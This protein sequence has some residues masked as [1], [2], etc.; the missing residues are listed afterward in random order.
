VQALADGVMSKIGELVPVTPVP[1]ACA[2]LQSL[3]RDFVLRSGLLA[4]MTEMRD[5]LVELNARVVREDRDMERTLERALRLLVMRRVL[6]PEGD[7]FAVL[8]RGRPLVSYYANS[9]AHLLG[10][11]EAGVRERDALPALLV[12]GEHPVL[13]GG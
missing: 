5:V 1:L 8:P 7:G 6:A 11:F 2:A 3:D 13:R 9:V 12:T 10:P 4:R